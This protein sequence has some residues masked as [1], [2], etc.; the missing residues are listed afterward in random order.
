MSMCFIYEIY[1][2]AHI[3]NN[4]TISTPPTC[5]GD[6]IAFIWVYNTPNYLK[7]VKKSYSYGSNSI[8]CIY[9]R[10]IRNYFNIICSIHCDYN[11]PYTPTNAYNLYTIIYHTYSW[12]LLHVSAI[13]LHPL[14][15]IIQRHIQSTHPILHIKW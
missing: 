2:R 10:D 11:P 13:N 14:G 8:R 4:S 12:T 3:I 5:S 6:Y 15:D 9:L 7:H 1:K